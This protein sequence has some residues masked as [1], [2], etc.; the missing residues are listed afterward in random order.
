MAIVSFDGRHVE[1][2]SRWTRSL[3]QLSSAIDAAQRRP[4]FG[5]QRLSEQRQFDTLARFEG[6]S[7]GLLD[8]RFF[9]RGTLSAESFSLV[10]EDE[11]RWQLSRVLDGATSAL[12]AF[13]QPPG[14]KVMLLLSGGWPASSYEWVTGSF[15]S[16]ARYSSWNSRRLFDPLIDT[17]NRLGYS[18][19]PVDL[20]GDVSN[21]RTRAEFGSL[22]DST[23][24]GNLADA[25]D[26]SEEEA[27]YF[28]AD[29]TGGRAAI[30]GGR[31][32]ALERTIEDTRSYYWLGFSPDWAENDQRHRV[33]V[34]MRQKGM[35][36]RTRKS[37]SDFSRQ[38]E[39]SMMV[40]SAQLF[41]LPLPGQG[42]L[43][44]SFGKPSKAGFKKV[45]VP[46]RLEIPL[47]QV[48]FVPQVDG[49]GARLELRV[50]ATDADGGNAEIPVLPVELRSA[51][52][53]GTEGIAVY[54]TQLRLR[55]KP[56]RL[57]LSLYDPASGNLLAKRVEIAL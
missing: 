27:L 40:E 43:A 42:D 41:D 25:R 11:L 32:R 55:A 6:R 53:S 7:R 49:F 47:D 23:I 24:A 12:R 4:A 37:F 36:A 28:L 2:L 52:G 18:L 30:D 21:R 14:R 56:H 1:M 33:K 44:V 29:A 20:N 10:R 39:V 48:T 38:S 50:A 31:F 46:V 54:E 34:E 3:L 22:I 9:G 57:L 16:S 8:S 45:L 51:S 13:A 26:Y 17:A 19:Y 35:K 5:L 15:F